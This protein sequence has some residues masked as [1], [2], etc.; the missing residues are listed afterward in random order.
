[1][2]SPGGVVEPG[3]VCSGDVPSLARLWATASF[4][5]W[6][7]LLDILPVWNMREK[8]LLIF[9]FCGLREDT[10]SPCGD[11]AGTGRWVSSIAFV[12]WS[13]F[14]SSEVCDVDETVEGVDSGTDGFM[15]VGQSARV[16]AEVYFV[17]VGGEIQAQDSEVS[18]AK[19]KE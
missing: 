16:A 10:A 2:R 9:C 3:E 15:C 4:T 12:I 6:T 17:Y 5:A 18:K 14:G 11:D 7:S 1:M 19:K 8:R 13:P